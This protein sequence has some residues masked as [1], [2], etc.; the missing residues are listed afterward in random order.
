MAE[1]GANV[2]TDYSALIEGTLNFQSG[3]RDI[4]GIILVEPAGSA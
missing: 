4:Y 1:G 3:C 2:K